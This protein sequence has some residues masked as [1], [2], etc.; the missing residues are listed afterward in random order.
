MVVSE[1]DWDK[2]IQYALGLPARRTGIGG[3]SARASMVVFL[4]FIFALVLQLV[5]GLGLVAYVVVVPAV[6]FAVVISMRWNNRSVAQYAVIVWQS[7]RRSL[8]GGELYVS[9]EFSRVPGGQRRLPG[10]LARTQLL[11]GRDVL[12]REF[13]VVL[14]RPQKEATVLLDV[15]FTGQVK[16][17]QAERNVQ[18]SGWCDFLAN[19]SLSGDIEQVVTVVSTRPGSGMLVADEVRSIVR[20]DAPEI[21]RQVLFEAA[22]AI[23]TGKPEVDGHIAITVKVSSGVMKDNEFLG[24]LATRVPSWCEMAGWSSMVVKPMSYERAVARVHSFFN[25]AAEVDFEQ[26][27]LSGEEH[28]LSWE[29]AGPGVACVFP[30]FY[31][32][33]GCRSVTWEMREAPRSTFDDMVLHGLCAPHQRVA[34]K[35]VALCYQPYAAGVSA[36]LVEKEHLDALNAANSSKKVRSAAAEMRLEHTEAARR[37]Q[38]KGSQLGRYS[39]FVTATLAEGEDMSR[40]VHDVEQLA[41]GSSIRLELMKRQQDAA[42][43]VACGFGQVPWVKASTPS[44]LDS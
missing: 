2:P 22:S 14:D 31:F 10:L 25:P 9:G 1:V 37:A 8:V 13:A 26:L 20:D 36:R 24:Q 39:L 29:D 5:G 4:G 38:A 19:L 33:D 32:H 34:R 17:T 41:A 21:A 6:G 18:T 42:F 28:G 43:Q 12:G 40:V 30:R 23:S 11:R 16:V 35:R 15:E 44:W 27:L 7:F 3:F